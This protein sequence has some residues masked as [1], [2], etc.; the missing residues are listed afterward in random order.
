MP[1]LILSFIFINLFHYL[2]LELF[3]HSFYLE[4]L[5]L[6]PY[7]VGLSFIC[8][9][10]F[11]RYRLFLPHLV[12]LIFICVFLYLTYLLLLSY[13]VGLVFICIF[14]ILDNVLLY[15][16]F[17]PPYLYLFIYFSYIDYVHL[18]PSTCRLIFLR[19]LIS[20]AKRVVTPKFLVFASVVSSFMFNK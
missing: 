5:L 20:L 14:C 15:L 2:F 11:R 19:L 9:F 13:L 7:Y 6:L 8:V 10:V 17:F 16:N 3:I 1:L 18:P 12:E 4:Y